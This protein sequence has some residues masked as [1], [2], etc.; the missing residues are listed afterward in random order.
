MAMASSCSGL[1]ACCNDSETPKEIETAKSIDLS[2]EAAAPEC[3]DGNE[4]PASEAEGAEEVRGDTKLLVKH[5]C[6]E[7]QR[8]SEVQVFRGEWDA[9]GVYFYQAYCDEIADWAVE[10]QQFGGPKFNASRMT[11]IKPSFAW[12]LYRSGYGRK[13]NQHRILKVKL[14]HDAVAALLRQCQCKDGGGG[15]KGRVQWDPARDLYSAEGREPRKLLRD[16]AIQIG[17]SGSLSEAYVR[18]VVSIEDVTPLAQRVGYAHL[19]RSAAQCKEGMSALAS[20]LPVERPYLPDLEEHELIRLKMRA[21]LAT[22]QKK[23]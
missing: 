10:H 21:P 19:L 13:H 2:P 1:A 6:V 16:R 3:R 7:P 22:L 8:G 14:P 20:E 17:L 5:E 23:H 12:M 15:S 9:E 4:L 18:S 11:W